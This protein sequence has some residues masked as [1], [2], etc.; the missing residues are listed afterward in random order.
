MMSFQFTTGLDPIAVYAAVVATVALLLCL[1]QWYRGGPRLH[2]H[3]IG[4]MKVH[5][6]PTNRSYINL[7]VYNRG[8]RKTTVTA[9]AIS[10]Y[11]SWW[12]AITGQRSEL[13]AIHRPLHIDLPLAIEAGDYFSG[14]I[15][16]TDDLIQHSRDLRLYIEVSYVDAENPC[17]FV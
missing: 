12:T 6:D 3:A 9:L 1:I 2:G 5:P 14:G 11:R 8:S 4:N 15:P 17:V 7:T 16:Q 13:F 10:A